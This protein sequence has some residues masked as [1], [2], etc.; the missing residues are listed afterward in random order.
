[1]RAER[2]EGALGFQGNAGRRCVQTAHSKFPPERIADEVEAVRFC[3]PSSEHEPIA[4]SASRARSI[5]P[6]ANT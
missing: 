3:P 2:T 1:M 6:K 5:S 4:T